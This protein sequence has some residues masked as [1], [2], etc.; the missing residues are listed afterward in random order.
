MLKDLFS[1][2]RGVNLLLIK[3]SRAAAMCGSQVFPAG[4][5]LRGCRPLYP[6][7]FLFY[8]SPPAAGSATH[9]KLKGCRY[10]RQP[11]FPC[12]AFLR[13][14]R[15]LYPAKFLFFIPPPAA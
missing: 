11:M 5:F 7:K 9:K 1:I 13:G 14:C 4:A 2:C 15:P 10:M 6:A 8:I 12:G 3:N